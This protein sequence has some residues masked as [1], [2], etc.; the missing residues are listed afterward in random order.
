MSV[1][2]FIIVGLGNPGKE[3]EN[4]RH[5]VGFKAV[6]FISEKIG[7]SVTS[8]KFKGLCG[9]TNLNGKNI[10]ILKPTTYMNLSGEAVLSDMSFYKVPSNKVILLFDD[11][12]FEVGTFKIKK[13][14]S[15]GG[16][17]GVKNII[18]LTHTDDFPR[19]KI[20]IGNKPNPSWDLADWV[21][22][23]FTK[24]EES[25]LRNIFNDVYSSISL[26]IDGEIERAMNLFN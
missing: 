9:K 18:N 12:S 13:R 11:I 24:C 8:N 26:I 22:S 19:I 7:C 2:D 6:D 1:I 14:G 15:Y 3:Y 4:T 5:N 10:L 16:Q 20:G 23:R 25:A 17:N 21:L